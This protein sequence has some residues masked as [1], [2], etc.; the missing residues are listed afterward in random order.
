MYKDA[1][2]YIEF[3]DFLNVIAAI[4]PFLAVL[5][6]LD[7]LK[8]LSL[9]ISALALIFFSIYIIWCFHMILKSKGYGIGS[10]FKMLTFGPD[11]V[12]SI[13]M[14]PAVL[15]IY[16]PTVFLTS[17]IWNGKLVL[18]E[19]LINPQ[20]LLGVITVGLFFPVAEEVIFRGA[21]YS[22]LERVFSAEFSIVMTSVAFAVVHPFEDWMRSFVLGMILNLL[23]YKRRTLTVP[24][25]IH[26]MVNLLYLSLMYLHLLRV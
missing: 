25:T 26:V 21:L 10:W 3:K 19:L 16:L 9:Q 4:F 17:Y 23:Y 22:Y 18:G 6:V 24:A 7:I 8:K 20:P 15:G 14:F 12:W 5:F 2:P 13:I 11:L 1:E